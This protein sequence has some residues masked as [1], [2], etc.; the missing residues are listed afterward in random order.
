MERPTDL[1][2]ER[3]YAANE[4]KEGALAWDREP[5]RSRSLGLAVGDC[6]PMGSSILASLSEAGGNDP[7]LPISGP[8]PPHVPVGADRVGT[9]PTLCHMQVGGP[10][11]TAVAARVLPIFNNLTCALKWNPGRR[12]PIWNQFGNRCPESVWASPRLRK[13]P[14]L[15]D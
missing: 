12:E 8:L 11:F 1:R 3:S 10:S 5:Q 6:K 2:S 4:K 15:C 14:Y 13:R 7:F 9:R